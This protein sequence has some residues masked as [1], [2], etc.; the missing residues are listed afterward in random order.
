MTFSVT[1][2]T[3]IRG[4][5]APAQKRA[6][7]QG[8]LH[9]PGR[10]EVDGD[11]LRFHW[12]KDGTTRS[13]PVTRDALVDLLKLAGPDGRDKVASVAKRWGPLGICEHFDKWTKLPVSLWRCPYCEPGPKPSITV[14]K[15]HSWIQ[16]AK[17]MD[18]I[19][20]LAAA[21]RERRWFGEA[22]G[23]LLRPVS[24]PMR[25]HLATNPEDRELMGRHLAMELNCLTTFAGVTPALEWNDGKLAFTWWFGGLY[26]A[27][28][29]RLALDAA[30]GVGMTPCIN[31]GGPVI[32][33]P[34]FRFC[35]DCR[36]SGVPDRLRQRRHRAK[37]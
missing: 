32:K 16:A 7:G 31:C 24:P 23:P 15:I 27:A 17:W 22:S 9:L 26:A 35:D 5:E 1:A 4:R 3:A 19:T 11:R 37:S 20:R 2:R 8:E 14:E 30:S 21:V 34:R 28:G 29:H 33:G 6:T 36:A 18:K 10:I 13:V 12:A 25:I